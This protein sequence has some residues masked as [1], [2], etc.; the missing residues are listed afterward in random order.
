MAAAQPSPGD[1]IYQ[2]KV[3]L[4]GSKPPIWRRVQ[5]PSSV[6][7]ATLHRVIQ[8][9]MGWQDYHLHQFI[10]REK[11]Y[12][13]RVPDFDFGPPMENERL[14]KLSDVAPTMLPPLRRPAFYMNMT[15][16]TAGSTRSW[17]RRSCRQKREC[18]I[19]SA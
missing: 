4:K 14:V 15:S 2:L 8:V 10:S 7:L 16:V 11:Y 12:G 13:Q 9:V 18:T 17:W 3:T 19:L 6:T 5:V 1:P